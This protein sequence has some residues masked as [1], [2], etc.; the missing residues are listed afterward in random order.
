MLAFTLKYKTTPVLSPRGPFGPVDQLAA[1][2]VLLYS[3]FLVLFFFSSSLE[4]NQ[5]KD[6]ALGSMDEYSRLVFTF[7]EPIDDV[8]LRRD[9]ADAFSL[10]F[11]RISSGGVK[12][13]PSDDLVRSVS[14]SQVDNRLEAKVILDTHK[15]E[16]RHFLSRDRFS[17][18]VD[19]K[20]LEPLDSEEAD[21]N[22]KSG[23]GLAAIEKIKRENL[24]TPPELP[25]VASD[26]SLLLVDNPRQGPGDQLVKTGLK[27]LAK[28]RVEEGLD[29]LKRFK[30]QYPDHLNADPAWFLLGDAYYASGLPD[31]FLAATDAWKEAKTAFPDSIDAPRASFMIA[32]ANEKMGYRPEAGGFYKVCADEYPQSPFAPAALL[33]AAD[34]QLAMGLNDEAR[35]TLTP[36]LEKGTSDVFGLLAL[37]RSA[38]AD[39]QDS[40]FSQAVEKLRDALDEEPELYLLYPDMLYALGDGYSYLNRP[41]LTVLFLEHA[42][43]LISDHPKADVML[44][45][46]GNALQTLGRQPQA[47]SY[48]NYA[49]DRFPDKD[50]GL[51]SE[52]RLA[53]MGALSSFF[54][55]DQVFNALEWGARQ[56]TVKMYEKIISQASDSPLLQLAYLKLGQAQAADGENQQAVKWL[57]ELVVKYPKGV[58]LDEAKPILSR[59]VVN[60][61]QQSFN[62]GHYQEIERLSHD[63][64]SFLEGPD[65]LRFQRFL[66]QSYEKLGQ[67][68]KA[69]EVWKKIEEQS[70]ERRLNDQKQVVES[71]LQAL[72]PMEA[73]KQLKATLAEFPAQEAWVKEKAAETGKTLA[74]VSANGDI[75]DLI[76]FRNDPLILPLTEISQAA[77]MDAISILVAHRRYDQASSFMDLYRS[78]YPDDELS[79]EY[80]L[81]QAKMERRLGRINKSWDTLSNFR[82]QYPDHPLAPTTILDTAQEART[83][84]RL[85]DAFRYEELYRLLYPNDIIS[86]NLILNRASELYGLGRTQDCLDTLSYFQSEYPD[87]PGAPATY[88]DQYRKLL[89]LDNINSAQTVLD[90]LRNKYPTDPLTIESYVIEY[91]DLLKLNQPNQAFES[92]NRFHQLY[93]NDP[94]KPDLLLEQ[95]KDYFALNRPTQGLK[96]WNDFLALFPQDSR[97]AELTLLLAR[98]EMRENQYPQALNHFRDYLNKYLDRSDR[99]QVTLELAAFESEL[100][101]NNAAFDDLT[102]FRNNFPDSPQEPDV[103]LDQVDLAAK[104]GRINDAAGLYELFRTKYPTHPKFADSFLAQTRLELSANRPAQALATLEKGV[105]ASPGLDDTKAVQDLLLQLYLDEGRV[106][107]WA[108]AMEE[109]LRR[110]G[111]GKGNLSERFAKYSQVAQVYQELGRSQ[112]AQKNFDLALENRPPDVSG[113]SLYAIAGAYRRM[114]QEDKYKSVLEMILQS[115]DPLWKNVAQQELSNLS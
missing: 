16:V 38:M 82:I 4:A 17:C 71:A 94:R 39:Y 63:N 15:F 108:G 78:Q 89:E 102:S 70:P 25:K 112:D 60:Q 35:K 57:K 33:K 103:L 97:A 59:A 76:N 31:N 8:V 51:V 93:P 6:V 12:T 62:L 105:V 50:G 49:K 55:P 65:M 11:G 88:I 37:A 111:Q 1:T 100:G 29:K 91:R 48:F 45:R 80:M 58:L 40:L 83:L 47:I 81:T 64:S 72:K 42:L 96:A 113:E 32:L 114:G 20:N 28:G 85:E 107:D 92:L 43:N 14:V 77:L 41:D 53:D 7:Q 79:P 73:F 30:E 66:A 18:I 67:S 68:E 27:D 34:M 21:N 106:E 24:L 10:D 61:A 5:L 86:R 9:D 23:G 3:L 115:P 98:R 22:D 109:Y 74:K 69:L 46:I 110:E 84:G 87:D 90:K 56:A 52:I 36:L 75:D 13:G 2:I 26:L 44:A 95:A 101:L 104:M 54:S 99:A 19:F